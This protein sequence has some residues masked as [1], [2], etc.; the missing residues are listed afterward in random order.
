MHRESPVLP[1]PVVA[2]P[3]HTR[4]PCWHRGVREI[5]RGTH[6]RPE[7]SGQL[8]GGGLRLFFEGARVEV[9]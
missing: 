7:P 6:R 4:F 9:A 3:I 8:L 2:S 1:P 5:D